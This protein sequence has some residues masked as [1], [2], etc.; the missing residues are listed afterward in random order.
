MSFAVNKCND[1]FNL[2]R[3]SKTIAAYA[4]D[5]QSNPNTLCTSMQIVNHYIN[6]NVD[7]SQYV[8]DRWIKPDQRLDIKIY[9]S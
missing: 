5:T 4:S 7:I 2:D 9:L 8:C 6:V 3:K 1:T